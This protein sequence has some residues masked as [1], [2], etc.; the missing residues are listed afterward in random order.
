MSGGDDRLIAL[1]TALA[2]AE[3]MLHDLSEVAATQADEIDRLR[4]E[5][6]RLALRIDRLE[7]GGDEDPDL[8]AL[9]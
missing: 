5:T 1:E 6:R 8:T 3:A 7:Q 4:T 9:G 2:H